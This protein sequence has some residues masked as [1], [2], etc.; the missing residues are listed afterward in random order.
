[1]KWILIPLAGLIAIVL[2][3]VIIGMTLPVAHVAS[4]KARFRQPPQVVFDA[5]SGPGEWR[6][7]LAKIEPLPSVNGR[8]RWKEISKRGDAITF[9]L[10]DSTPPLRRVTRIADENLPFSGGW[11]FEIAPAAGGSTLRITERG[12]VTNPIFRFV[13]RFIIGHYRT[14]DTYLNDLARKFGET[15]EIEK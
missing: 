6:G 11:T 15:L 13:S 12:E 14:I 7:D 3:I 1:M 5:I 10:M 8:Q 4:R 2:L 9:E